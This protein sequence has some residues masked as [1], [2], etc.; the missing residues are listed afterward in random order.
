M[1]VIF[2]IVAAALFGA[3]VFSAARLYEQAWLLLEVRESFGSLVLRQN[4]D[5]FY[6]LIAAAFLAATAGVLTVVVLR[7]QR[8]DAARRLAGE[9]E[10]QTADKTARLSGE[11]ARFKAILDTLQDGVIY[12]ENQQIRYTNRAIVRMIGYE[13]NAAD[14][15]DTQNRLNG[16]YK[17]LSSIAGQNGSSQGTFT[18][19]RRDGSEFSAR[20]R[21]SHIGENGVVTLI[22]DAGQEAM[23]NTLKARFV[24]NASHELRTPLA[25]LKTRLYLIRRQPEKAG[26]HLDVV[27]QVVEKMQVLIEEMFDFT[28]FGQGTALLD[29]RDAKLQELVSGVAE[30]YRAKAESRDITLL[31]DLAT[32]PLNVFVDPVRF[33][34]VLTNLVSSAMNHTRQG[35]TVHIRAARDVFASDRAMLQV[36]DNGVGIARDL[37]DQVFQPFSLAKHGDVSG[38]ALGLTLSKEIVELHGGTIQA[39]SEPGKGTVFTIRLP[40]LP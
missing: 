16:L 21:H 12:T 4:N 20:V 5:A 1:P 7:R 34:Q 10:R 27:E 33:S 25:N 36:A 40:L 32:E 11:L 13:E 14:D 6:A 23:L 26:D 15:E 28:Q 29:R 38:T 2:L 24:S 18:I 31:C 3:V 8:D 30:H 37:L 35:G 22:Q 9:V 19:L 39:E 17:S